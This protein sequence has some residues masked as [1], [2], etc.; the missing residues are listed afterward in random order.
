MPYSRNNP[1][2]LIVGSGPTGMILAHE[3]LRRG[4]SV[5]L[6]EKRLGPSHTTRAM[7]VHARSME[8]FDHMGV[9]HRLEEV[10]AEAPGNIYHF[11][12]REFS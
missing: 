2:V 12:G 1:S 8:M 10:C 11:P 5:R 3:L 7:T 6:L 9:A 4:V